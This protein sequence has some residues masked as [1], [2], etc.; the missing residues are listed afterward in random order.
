[1]TENT[2]FVIKAENQ[3]MKELFSLLMN[4]IINS[5]LEHGSNIKSAALVVDGRSVRQKSI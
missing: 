3:L 4:T 2:D 1:M 5:V